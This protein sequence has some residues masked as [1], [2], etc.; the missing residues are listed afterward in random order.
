MLEVYLLRK[1]FFKSRP[2]SVI[3]LNDL[4]LRIVDYLN[5]LH[6]VPKYFLMKYN[7][8]I[9]CTISISIV[10]T[11]DKVISYL[12]PILDLIYF[13]IKKS[14]I[15]VFSVP[16]VINEKSYT[17]SGTYVILCWRTRFDFGLDMLLPMLVYVNQD[18]DWIFPQNSNICHRI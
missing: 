8:Y 12:N 15:Y 4:I 16:S 17:F 6:I 9:G 7:P 18:S 5:S 14:L 11:L 1:F 13:N 3:Y 10:S 2:P